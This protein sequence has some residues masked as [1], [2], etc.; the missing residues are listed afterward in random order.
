MTV[1]TSPDLASLRTLM[2]NEQIDLYFVPSSDPHQSEYVPHCWERRQFV[3]GFTGSAGSALIGAKDAYLWTDGRYFLQAES[4]LNENWQLMRQGIDLSLVDWLAQQPHSVCL[5]VDPT[6]VT[7]QEAEQL[8]TA[9]DQQG[10]QIKWLTDNLIDK[11]WSERPSLPKQSAWA[12]SIEYAGVEAAD[13]IHAIRQ[14]LI[15]KGCQS[16]LINRLDSIAWLLNIRGNDIDYNPLCISYLIVTQDTAWW[17]VHPHKLDSNM[18]A[19]ADSQGIICRHYKEYWQ[20]LPT[21]AG[22]V[23]IDPNSASFAE[24]QAIGVSEIYQAPCPVYAAKAIKNSAEIEGA[25]QAHL[26]D[27]LALCDFFYWLEHE[28]TETVTE[29]SAARRLLEARQKQP[30]FKQQSFPS[31]SGFGD[32]GAV[33]H[34]QPN[35]QSDTAVDDS[36]LYLLDSGGQYPGGTTDVTRV[37]HLGE[38]TD[39]QRKHYTLVLKAHLA[40]RQS[41]FP[42][43]T[44]G[45]QLDTITRQPLWREGLDFMHGTGH[46]V[47]SYLCVHEGPQRIGR[48]GNQVPIEQGMIVSNEP[49]LYFD[50]KYGIRIENLCLIS[51]YVPPHD[52]PYCKQMLCLSDLTLFPYEKKLIDR[53]LLSRQEIAAINHYHTM[54]YHQLSPHIKD[55]D[56]EHWLACKTNPIEVKPC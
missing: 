49:G 29:L 26:Q 50:G 27:G 40:L 2:R 46:G 38:P 23:W 53:S 44:T 37:V 30:L 55:N 28:T 5:G 19:Y 45:D 3:S 15:T 21:I 8:Q 16:L 42:L 43:G 35:E 41:I 12:H 56:I 24:Q 6:C 39:N 9:L 14:Q 31:I 10:G 51:E 7:Q 25:R 18:Q 47:G 11:I 52:S 4:E 1:E 13:K 48:G 32:N 20:T 36:S 34:Y 17:F 54:V 22:P 33:I